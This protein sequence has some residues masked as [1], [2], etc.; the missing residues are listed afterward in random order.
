MRKYINRNI[1][2]IALGAVLL[3]IGGIQEA[4]AARRGLFVGDQYWNPTAEMQRRCRD[5]KMTSIFLFTLQVNADGALRFNDHVIVSGAGTWV[6][7]SWGSLVAGCRGNY[8]NRI[9]LALGNWGTQSFNNIRNLVNAGSPALRRNFT[10]LRN[11]VNLDAI[12][13][14]D[15]TTYDRHS[16]VALCQML[17]QVGFPKVTLCPY[18]NQSFWAGVKSDLGS[19]VGAVYLQCY[20]GG[21]GN[22]ATSW[23]S[24]LGNT[25]VLYPGE[26]IFSGG[27]TVTSRM[28]TWRTQGFP[29]G[30]IWGNNQLPDSNWGQW[31]IDAGF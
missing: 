4:S 7:G 12:Q 22:S 11:N 15:E 16:M 25:S 13:M 29:G 19:N 20:D 18:T 10:T 31:L 30:F 5:S 3:T 23:R 2:I 6:G 1:A 9:E 24:A 28:T 8:V 21:A 14:D 17:V 27:S 26:W